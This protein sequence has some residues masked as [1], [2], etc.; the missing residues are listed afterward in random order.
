MRRK[1]VTLTRQCLFESLAISN[2]L[3]RRDD[4]V[5]CLVFGL[6]DALEARTAPADGP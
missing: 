6:I 2:W 4:Q 3:R 5:G 1:I